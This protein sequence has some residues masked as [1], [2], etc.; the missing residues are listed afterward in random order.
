MVRKKIPKKVEKEIKE[1]I[2][3]LH[4]DKLPIKKVI[5]FGSYA[6]GN[7]DRDSDIDL[8]ILTNDISKRKIDLIKEVRKAI[9]PV[10][11]VP[12]DILIYGKREFVKIVSTVTYSLAKYRKYMKL[13]SKDFQTNLM[14]AVTEVNGCQLCSYFHTKN[15]IDS[16]ISNQELQS[17]LSGD[18]EFV[19]EEEAQA[20]MFAQ[21]YASEKEDYSKETF[22]KIIEHYG[23]EQAYGILA[24]LT[25][26]S[27][28]NANG[29]SFG[30]F[31]S[32]FT[33]KGRVQGSTLINELF[34]VFSPVV[35]MPITFIINMFRQKRY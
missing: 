10:A 26:I 31:K 13:I 2:E 4:K 12:V 23:K 19:K 8:C 18:H 28:G 3:V 5:L 7:P 16:G 11:L 30:N 29:I 24:S 25:L 15:A 32:R 27:F 9:T 6:Y 20:L 17:L 35:L 34:I 22:Q 33:K 21:H 14:L 1:Y